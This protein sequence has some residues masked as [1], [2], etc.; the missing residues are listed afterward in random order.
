MIGSNYESVSALAFGGSFGFN[1]EVRAIQV[2]LFFAWVVNY[3]IYE[4]F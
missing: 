2:K 4:S 1:T 3:N